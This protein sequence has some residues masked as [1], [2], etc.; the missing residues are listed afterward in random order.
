MV[1]LQEPSLREV[2]AFPMTSGGQTAVMEAP[3]E[4]DK[5][6]LKEL[7]IEIAPKKIN[8]VSSKKK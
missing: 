5:E 1:V 8:N 7:G 2:M 3:S 6:Q 4:V